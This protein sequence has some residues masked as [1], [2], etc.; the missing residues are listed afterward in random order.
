MHG[1]RLAKKRVA[2]IVFAVV[3]P[4]AV[5]C[6]FLMRGQIDALA[7]ARYFPNCAFY[8]ATGYL[9]PG[10]GTTRSVLSILQGNVGMAIVYN[11]IIPALGV[12]FVLLYAEM[13]IYAVT[14]QRRRILPMRMMPYM[15]VISV[16]LVYDVVRNFIPPIAAVFVQ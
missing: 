13:M 6:V 15:I 12:L 11:P 14:G 2:A 16:I 8:E 4:L 1:G 5:V 7:H 9:C 3:I 10:C